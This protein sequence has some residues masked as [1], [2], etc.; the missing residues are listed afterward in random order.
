MA[1][2]PFPRERAGATLRRMPAYL[3]LAWRLGRDPLLSRVRRGAVLAA[4]GYLASPIDLVPGVIPVLGQLDDIAVALAALKFALAGL[5]GER[6]REHLV[7]VGLEDG[8]LA[9]DLRTV[10]ATSAW[11]VRAGARTTGRAARQ[12][13]RI[14]VSG[15]RVVGAAASRAAPVAR[16]AAA[17][18]GPVARSAAAKAR[19]AARTAASAAAKA[20]PAARGAASRGAAAVKGVASM[21]PSMPSMKVRV[22]LHRPAAL[23][24]GRSPDVDEERLT[25]EPDV[26]ELPG[27]GRDREAGS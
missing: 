24:P 13:G 25:V 20:G 8:H 19:P 26:I 5:D 11:L 15:A 7:A 16:S 22:S 12:G 27:P 2:D 9:E 14:A 18:A 23:G 1:E 21:R 6:R 4:A 3:K 10:G 17:K